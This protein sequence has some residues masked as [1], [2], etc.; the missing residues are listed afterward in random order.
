MFK[1]KFRKLVR[2]PKLFFNDMV[3]KNKKRLVGLNVYPSDSEREYTVI[4]AVYNVEKYLDDYF[5]SLTKQSL[6]F[7]R[8]IKLIVVD[9]G[10]TDSSA[11]I[12]KRW[13]RKYPYNIYYKHKENGGQGS[14]RNYGLQFANSEWVTYI[15]PDDFVEKDYFK[16]ID[17]VINKNSDLA[18]V[19]CNFI[20]FKEESKTTSNTHPL[21]YRFE[22]NKKVQISKM[23]NMLQMHV[24]SVFFK[25]SII[26]KGNILFDGRI[27]PNFEDGH[28]VAKYTQQCPSKFIYFCKNAIY[29]YRKREDASSALDTSW[30]K[31]GK[32][33]DVLEHGYL[34]LLRDYSN[35]NKNIPK[36]IQ[37]TV[38]YELSWHFKHLLQKPERASFLTPQQKQNY[39]WLISS[40]FS[41]IDSKEI[42]RFNLAGIWF[43]HKFGMLQAFKNELPTFQIVYVDAFDKI[44]RKLKIKYFI[45]EVNCNQNFYVDNNLVKPE[46]SKIVKHDFLDVNFCKEVIAWLDI[47]EGHE[48]FHAN[49]S[50]TPTMISFNGEN[51][52]GAI[53][54]KDIE[55]LFYK[56]I[57]TDMKNKYSNCWLFMDKD[58]SADDNAE[59]FYRYIAKNHSEIISYF[60]LKKGTKDW[61]RLRND[62][63]KLISFG[64]KE[65]KDALKH[66]KKLISSHADH[67]VTN[68]LG[69]ETLKGKQFIFLQH[70]VIKDDL[71]SWIN[72]KKQ[73]DLLITTSSDEYH[74]I[75]GND[76]R[77]R[78]T[79]KEVVL[80]G[81][82]RHDSL[83][84]K[85]N[86][87]KYKNN[88][89]I[90][91]PT[92]RRNIVSDR[93][94]LGSEFETLSNFVDT[95]YYKNWNNL[96]SSPVFS[97][98]IK[99]YNLNV[100]F[101]P[102]DYVKPYMKHFQLTDGIKLPSPE[103]TYQDLLSEAA[104]MITDYSSVAFDM[105]I[106]G[107][108]TF[109]FQFDI[110][111]F[112]N[113]DHNYTR[114]YF[115]YTN[116]GFGPVT[117]N[118]ETLLIELTSYFRNGRHL[119]KQINTRIKKF[120]T[121]GDGK[122]CERIYAAVKSL[123]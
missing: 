19:S 46:I 17:S 93:N 56:K 88:T 16:N 26:E 90:I 68:L 21:R 24:N 122:S 36:F 31:L 34:D 48:Y 110:D 60:V 42:I 45:K 74:S 113:G 30:S 104:L 82:A 81:L 9:D 69:K 6:N 123:D 94:S 106:Q 38:I 28:F 70:G 117:R 44:K 37:W 12:I 25:K 57:S 102:H 100:I 40:I 121:L 66:C 2:D 32:F 71:S 77:Y 98:I 39:I 95:E 83:I 22:N 85:M 87:I 115:D 63:F 105:A 54:I 49:I 89:V 80:T 43:Y 84:K 1:R 5:K 73:I 33:S 119:T 67:Y 18:M 41:F 111:T 10:S 114:G 62:G 20:F 23:D 55:D 109:Y 64:S 76:T 108:P 75:C 103:D 14:A 101:A 51:K 50:D 79:S 78:L 96:I 107:K 29:F 58:I 59:H 65:H 47:P 86:E 99:K 7:K 8:N 27:R 92:W 3:L 52:K 91:M 13:Q 4:S 97:K 72:T 61:R 120:A 53:K 112:F 118:I 11:E 116:N 15:D 35:K